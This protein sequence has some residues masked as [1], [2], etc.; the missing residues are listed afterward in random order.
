MFK[1]ELLTDE[2]TRTVMDGYK[3]EREA[4]DDLSRF[5]DACKAK[6]TNILIS[7]KGKGYSSYTISAV[8][9]IGI[10]DS[11]SVYVC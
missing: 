3:T 4:R 6:M 7:P 9:E 8:D 2:G 1:I 10:F 11:V 5:I